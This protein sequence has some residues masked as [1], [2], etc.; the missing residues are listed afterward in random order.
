MRPYFKRLAI[1]C[2][3]VFG[4]LLAGQAATCAEESTVPPE[5]PYI[6][7]DLPGHYEI[8]LTYKSCEV[9][10]LIKAKLKSIDV[11]E[12]CSV[13]LN[14]EWF[15]WTVPLM[16]IVTKGSD[17]FNENMYL[18]DS[19]GTRYDHYQGTGVAYRSAIISVFRRRG[20]FI[21]HPLSASCTSITFFDD[22]QSKS[23]GPIEVRHSAP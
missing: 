19:E 17:R 11:L 18:V 9:V 23:V 5:P 21:F 22:D 10:A 4:I 7:A 16:F 15:A 8:N 20:A 13:R 3:V 2:L 1:L 14:M 12:D 6:V